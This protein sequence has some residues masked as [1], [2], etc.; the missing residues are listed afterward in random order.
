M[1]PPSH[2][3]P[4]PD[5]NRVRL[6]PHPAGPCRRFQSLTHACQGMWTR[7][8]FEMTS[9]RKKGVWIKPSRDPRT[10]TPI[11]IYTQEDRETCGH[12]PVNLSNVSARP[13]QNFKPC[14][15]L[16]MI[17]DAEWRRLRL[18][19]IQDGYRLTRTTSR[20]RRLRLFPTIRR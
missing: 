13:R 8:D 1:V 20:C 12:L 16:R 14:N 19:C 10:S 3:P 5:P 4:S 2:S 7:P 11:A 17:Q 15:R 6:A 18:L 9:A